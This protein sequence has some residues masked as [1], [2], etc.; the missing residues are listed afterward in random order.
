MAEKELKKMSRAELIEIIYAL[1]KNEEVLKA[2]N[3]ALQEKLNDKT[4]KI[5]QS[6][7]IAEAVIVLNGIFQKAQDTADQYIQSVQC[8][9]ESAKAETE[10]VLTEAQGTA[11]RIVKEAE[12]RRLQIENETEK[13]VAG[14]WKSFD[15]KVN[16]MLSAHFALKEFLDGKTTEGKS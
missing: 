9:Q 16:E 13:E 14:K 5:Q 2:E 6:G 1:K 10:R 3:A 4:V 11:E 12:E 7:S 15:N 8:A